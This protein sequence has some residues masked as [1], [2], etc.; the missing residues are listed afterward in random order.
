MKIFLLIFCFTITLFGE[1]YVNK[2][3]NTTKQKIIE[4]NDFNDDFDSEFTEG[5]ESFVK[6]DPLSGYNRLMTNFNDFVYVN[7]LIPTATMYG[8]ALPSAARKSISN[9]FNNLTFPIRFVN[10]ILQ[11]KFYNAG[12][13]TSRFVINSTIGVLGFFDPAFNDFGIEEH[14]EDF[15]QTLGFYGVGAGPHIVLPIFGPSNLRDTISMIPDN[16]LN[17]TVG[18]YH[19]SSITTTDIIQINTLYY[20]NKTSL[21][22]GE[23][24]SIKKDAIDLYPFIRDLY[25]Q[26]RMSE[27]K[28]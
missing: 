9:A 4:N 2:Q 18:F 24:E 3:I 14:R 15:G 20:L 7:I 25:E 11:L 26:K 6:S 21:H 19:D 13:E 17:S 12:V 16:M 28:E 10:N 1:P 27:I 23:Y 8:D 22:L 5:R